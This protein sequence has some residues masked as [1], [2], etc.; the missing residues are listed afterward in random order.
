MSQYSNQIGVVMHNRLIPELQDLSIKA[1]GM[2]PY[3]YTGKV[4]EYN[5]RLTYSSLLFDFLEEY[6][7]GDE[8]MDN[9]KLVNIVNLLGIPE[10]QLGSI[11]PH[12]PVPTPVVSPCAVFFIDNNKN[13]YS[14]EP[15]TGRYAI[16]LTYTEYNV[17]VDIASSDTKLWIILQKLFH[18]LNIILH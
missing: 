4:E 9:K 10:F 1:A 8:E 16:R 5:R 17:S 14:Y 3:N 6:R 12:I 11:T 7:S 18:L 15:S 13:I 2:E